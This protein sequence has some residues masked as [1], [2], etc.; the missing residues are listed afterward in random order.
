MLAVSAMFLRPGSM[1]V[2]AMTMSAVHE[3]MHQ[4]AQEQQG[5]WQETED[6]GGMLHY[7]VE[8]RNGQESYYG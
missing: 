5:I 3:Q 8:G 2:S 1:P 4:R 6:V 7:Q